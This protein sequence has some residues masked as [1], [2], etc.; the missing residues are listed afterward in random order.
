VRRRDFIVALAGAASLAWSSA[1]RA[2]RSIPTVGLLRLAPG[3]PTDFFLPDFRDDLKKRGVVEG[4]DL[5]L[6]IVDAAGDGEGLAAAAGELAAQKPDVVVVFGDP[7]T[8]AVQQVTTSIP[9]VA[10]TDDMVGSKLVSSLAR[11]GSNTTGLS[12]LASELDVKRLGLLHEAV[13]H[14]ARIGVL[15]DR[16]T[17]ATRTRLEQAAQRLG[18]ELVVANYATSQEALHAADQLTAAGVG[19]VNVLATPLLGPVR[20]T[21]I[22]EFNHAGLPAIYQ[23]PEYARLGALIAYGPDL[24][25]CRQQVAAL[26]QK[27]LSGTKPAILPVEQPAKF[28]LIINLKTANA[29][30]INVPQ[31]LLAQADEVI[32]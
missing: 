6:L 22:D 9:I 26:V 18:V 27:I 21:V 15:A 20:Q 5:R 14:A 12:I 8:R 3:D 19:A 31:L 30:A 11:P 32:E 4:R 10:M 23:W 24:L 17:V 2:E 1:P 29:L 13:P 25:A 16:S 28:E 7:A